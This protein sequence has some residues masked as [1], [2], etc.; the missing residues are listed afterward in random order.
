MKEISTKNYVL[1]LTDK[2]RFFLDEREA[3]IVR[4]AIKNGDKYLEIDDSLIS[5]YSF[6]K[7][8]SSTNY[9]ETEKVRSGMWKCGY[10]LWHEK[11]MSCGH[12]PGDSK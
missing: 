1:V 3:D 12:R 2:S 11:N 9:E 4:Y 7:L 8:V 10:D 5:V 6:S